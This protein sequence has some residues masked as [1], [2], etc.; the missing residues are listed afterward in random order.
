MHVFICLFTYIYVCMYVWWGIR[1]TGEG[2]STGAKASALR[3]FSSLSTKAATNL[4]RISH[5]AT[6][7][8]TNWSRIWTYRVSMINSRT[9][10]K[11][12]VVRQYSS[13][14]RAPPSARSIRRKGSGAPR[15]RAP[16]PARP[17]AG[18]SL[19]IYIYTYT[20]VNVYIFIYI[21]TYIYI[22]IYLYI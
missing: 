1:R 2:G 19:H 17:D 3:H 20:R 16:G 4:D 15:F 7:S 14:P 11:A 5:C 13:R 10:A 6:A 8:G 12:S 18:S 22:Y 21:Y 9:G